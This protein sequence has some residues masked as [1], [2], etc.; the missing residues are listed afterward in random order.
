MKI[1]GYMVRVVSFA[2]SL[3]F[4][5]VMPAL[6]QQQQV[7]VQQ[8]LIELLPREQEIA[9]ALSAAPEHL[10]EDATVYVFNKSGYIKSHE[11]TNGFT[12]LVNRDAILDGESVLKPTCWDAEGSATVVPMVLRVGE[13]LAQD[14]SREEIQ[15]DIDQRFRTGKFIAPRKAGVAY[16]L[17]G[18][19][20]QYNAIA[21]R[22]ESRSFPPHLMFYAPNVTNADIGYSPEAAAKN[23]WLPVVWGRGANHSYIVVVVGDSPGHFHSRE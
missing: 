5:V 16:M 20:D 2:I 6:A 14:K 15:H 21:N 7:L 22:V 3:M 11:G 9:L 19:I 17:A 1:T 8:K 18:D 23:P 12:C 4:I 10:R 13:L